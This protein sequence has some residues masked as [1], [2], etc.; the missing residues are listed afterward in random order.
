[1]GKYISVSE[2]KANGS[3]ANL[4]TI[5]NQATSAD[6]I[7]GLTW[8]QK[9]RNE[10]NY[11]AQEK[12]IPFIVTAAVV[13]LLSPG[14]AW[15][16]NVPAASEVIDIWLHGGGPK[17]VT[18]GL[19][20]GRLPVTKAFRALEVWHKEQVITLEYW[21]GVV[22]ALNPNGPK[23]P[24][25][26]DNL[27]NHDSLRVTIDSHALAAWIGRKANGSLGFKESVYTLVEYQYQELAKRNGLKP[28]QLQ[29]TIWLIQRRLYGKFKNVA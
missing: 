22:G 18:F 19:G 29:A 26:F 7:E 11:I 6:R 8:Y 3:T 4:Q 20:A 17:D 23:V 10:I 14:K 25:F 21:Q 2:C 13:A 15:H 9:A 24:A 12:D 16:Q 27:V 1:M 28:Y 5:L